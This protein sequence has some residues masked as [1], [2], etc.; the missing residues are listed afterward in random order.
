M[1]DLTLSLK[2]KVI[3]VSLV[4]MAVILVLLYGT[5]FKPKMAETRKLRH[6][7]L[8]LNNKIQNMGKTIDAYRNGQSSLDEENSYFQ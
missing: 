2:Q 4:L 8:A 6:D 1:N 3:A 5:V 7:I